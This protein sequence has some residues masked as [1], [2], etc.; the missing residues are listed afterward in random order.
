LARRI[1][2]PARPR[3]SSDVCAASIFVA[4]LGNALC[5]SGLGHVVRDC[6][7]VLDGTNP[8]QVGSEVE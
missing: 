5:N 8:R 7:Q 1:R 2:V 4:S 3:L 6:K